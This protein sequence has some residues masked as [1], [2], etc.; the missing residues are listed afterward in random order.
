MTTFIKW[1]W[2]LI[3]TF[4]VS[5][6]THRHHKDENAINSLDIKKLLIN[7]LDGLI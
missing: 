2:N 4:N 6:I 1:N 5:V 3:I 7:R